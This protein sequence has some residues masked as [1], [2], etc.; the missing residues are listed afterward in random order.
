[1]LDLEPQLRRVKNHQALPLLQRALQQHVARDSS[2]RRKP[3]EP[4]PNF[5][6]AW[7]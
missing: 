1:L 6:Y 5:N 7:H 4:S 3:R 2:R